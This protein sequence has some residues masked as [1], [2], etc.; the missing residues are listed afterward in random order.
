MKSTIE[1]VAQR[2][3][4]SIA[5]V[6]RTFKHPE[7]VSRRTRERV[8]EAA[9]ELD[10]SISRSA[11]VFQ[12][13]QTLRIAL[14]INDRFASWFNSRVYE[15][16]DTILHP[17]G[18]DISVYPIVSQTDRRAF[19]EQLPT[20]RN[21]DA[22]VI[23]SFD[24]DPTEAERLRST[25]VPLI[26]INALPE[27]AF[28]AS[29]TID[30]EQAI[31]LAVRHLLALG[32]RNLAFIG[33]THDEHSTLRFSASRRETGFVDECAKT[34]VVPVVLRVPEDETRVDRAMT[35][36]LALDHLPTAICCQQDS[37]AVPLVVRLRQYGY[38][39][40]QDVSIV[41]FDDNFYARQ[42][43]LTTIRQNPREMGI[44]AAQ[45]TLALI[46]D[47]P[48]D[49]A[50]ETMPVELMFRSTTAPLER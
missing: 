15:G 20:R 39:V 30:D 19:F 5:T 8:M 28:S 47:E 21:V 48:I 26:G 18:Y 31:R 24:I 33:M 11:S 46:A 14:L 38:R 25:H 37:L 13:G 4:V 27:E 36:L 32:H 16:L 35:Q 12:T 42:I 50:H 3:G 41:G 23:P 29:I 7:I 10:F 6:S 40:P 2:A 44:K 43:G 45:Y 22:V 17:A 34:G 49:V 9:D 1:D